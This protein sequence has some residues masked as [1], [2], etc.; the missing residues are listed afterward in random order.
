MSRHHHDG[1]FIF[2]ASVG[3]LLNDVIKLGHAPTLVGGM[4]LI[5]LEAPRYSM[6]V[7]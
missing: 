7:A 4:T 3:K 6:E 2:I 5:T 1:I